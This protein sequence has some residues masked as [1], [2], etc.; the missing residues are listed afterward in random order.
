MS[1]ADSSYKDISTQS[2]Y[3]YYLL[4]RKSTRYLSNLLDAVAPL[5]YQQFKKY[6]GSLLN[7]DYYDDIF[8]NISVCVF[9][10]TKNSNEF[11]NCQQLYAY[12]KIIIKNAILHDMKEYARQTFVNEDETCIFESMTDNSFSARKMINKLDLEYLVINLVS[13]YMKKVNKKFR[14]KEYRKACV[15]AFDALIM[16]DTIN[17]RAVENQYVVDVDYVISYSTIIFRHC[18]HKLSLTFLPDILNG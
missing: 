13:M 5:Y 12:L 17:Y 11:N 18:L 3:E 2:I 15:Y 4:S 9:N 8:Q 6:S 7:E 10:I 1:L 14:S 16:S